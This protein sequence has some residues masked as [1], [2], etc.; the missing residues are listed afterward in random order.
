MTSALDVAV[1]ILMVALLVYFVVLTAAS[2][3]LTL[4]G[5]QGVNDY[6]RRRPMRAYEDVATS[7]LS[8]P[9]S[10][11]VPAHNEQ[12]TIVGS[13]RALLG[14]Q[15]SQFE[16]IVVND[17][18]T[19][20]TVDR[21]MAG[22]DMVPMQRVPS[23]KLPSRPVRGTYRSR[24]D[25][26]V[27]LIDKVRGGKADALNAGVNHARC[28]L[29]CSIDAD[30]LLDPWA[31]ARLVWE[32]QSDPD[33]VAVG[34]IVRVVNG[35]IFRG[36]RLAM[37]RTPRNL[38]ANLQ[39][40]EYL[41]AFLGARI[42]W[43]RIG[44]M[45]IISGAFGLFRRAAVVSAGGYDTNCVG[46]DAELV[47]RL[48]RVRAEAGLPCRI[49]FFP[50]PICWTEVPETMRVLASQRDRWQRGLAQ[51]LWRHR[52]MFGNPKYG[53]IGLL[54]VPYFWIFELFGPVVEVG[55]YIYVILGLIFGF[56]WIPFAIAL[57]LMSTALGVLLSMIVI[58]MEERA[59][60]RYPNWRD[61]AKLCGIA[62]LENC[63]Y[64][65]Y[66]AFVRLMAFYTLG[67][68]TGW[69]T[70]RRKGFRD[71]EQAGEI[72]PEATR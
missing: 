50:D 40:L 54:A 7:E 45:L 1:S 56:V 6:V 44:T 11:V 67:R 27:V 51:M 14:S 60:A 65:Q 12:E 52:R 30:T 72:A 43:S 48:H 5:W 28:P 39:V 13:V 71:D 61:L 15:F 8:M 26:R 37:V 23:D 63:G 55:G 69:G 53:K 22:L 42:G 70:M 19:D 38:L 2:T 62:V 29:I 4:I 31:L 20:A 49:T 34:G 68:R 35:S 36:G 17:G 18:S 64:R 25:Q 57:L 47:L 24:T 41:R 58:F 46:E 10:I 66:L 3:A 33:T 16:I 9:V 59:F 21:L 32:F